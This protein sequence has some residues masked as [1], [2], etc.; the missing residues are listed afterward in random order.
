[1]AHR[2]VPLPEE[3]AA[4]VP[5]R[6]E[7]VEHPGVRPGPEEARQNTASHR[8]TEHH[9]DAPEREPP[10]RGNV[11]GQALLVRPGHGHQPV[12]DAQVGDCRSVRLSIIVC[13]VA[14]SIATRCARSPCTGATR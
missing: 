4:A 11:R 9:G 12:Q 5:G 6:G 14:A 7:H 3:R 1:M 8:H 13:V 10:H 2:A